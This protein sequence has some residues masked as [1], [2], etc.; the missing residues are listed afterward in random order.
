M[1]RRPRYEHSH[2]CKRH[3]CGADDCWKPSHYEGGEPDLE[4]FFYAYCQDH[5]C[6]VQFCDDER[7]TKSG[8]CRTH[9]AKLGERED[10]GRCPENKKAD[11]EGAD[12]EVGESRCKPETEIEDWGEAEETEEAEEAEEAEEGEGEEDRL[13]DDE[14]NRP[15][16]CQVPPIPIFVLFEKQR[17]CPVEGCPIPKNRN[18]PLCQ[19]HKDKCLNNQCAN[20]KTKE[21]DKYCEEHSCNVF[22]CHNMSTSD[23]MCVDHKCGQDGCTIPKP[24]ESPL[25]RN[26]RNSQFLKNNATEDQERNEDTSTNKSDSIEILN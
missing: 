26:H 18:S 17:T 11:G 10:H 13:G 9:M 20:T 12:A 4:G 1:C 21:N 24:V 16:A 6:S 5:V 3:T 2:F 14:K 22:D 7:S 8:Y 23:N 25:C 15:H 19:Q